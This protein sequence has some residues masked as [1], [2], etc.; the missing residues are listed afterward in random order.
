MQKRG[1]VSYLFF[2]SWYAKK[3]GKFRDFTTAI[4][5][6]GMVPCINGHTDGTDCAHSN[7]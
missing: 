7:L 1:I 5:H 2:M 3:Q 4:V 6:E